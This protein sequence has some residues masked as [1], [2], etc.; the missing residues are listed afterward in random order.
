MHRGKGIFR[1]R[2]IGCALP[3]TIR[4]TAIPE[5][6]PAIIAG[7]FEHSMAARLNANGGWIRLRLVDFVE[8]AH[9]R[10]DDPQ[11]RR[12]RGAVQRLEWRRL[13]DHCA[14]RA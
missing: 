12:A 3:G 5:Q 10:P 1:I 13:F 2:S 8:D 7:A 14:S 9:S 6:L 11:R 4:R